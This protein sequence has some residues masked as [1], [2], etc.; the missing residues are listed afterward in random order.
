MR[1]NQL[2]KKVGKPYTRVEKYLV[3]ECGLEGIDGPNTKVD[4][5]VI[6]KV[7]YKFGLAEDNKEEAPKKVV[8]KTIEAVAAEIKPEEKGIKEA[9]HAINAPTPAEAVKPKINL[10][11]VQ[12][13]PTPIVS[14]EVASEEPVAEVVETENEEVVTPVLEVVEEPEVP[15]TNEEVTTVDTG[16]TTLHIDA[17]GV[18]KAPKVEL[19]GIK[20][21]GKIDLP[22]PKEEV[23]EEEE[24]G[25]E[26]VAEETV[27]SDE[28]PKEEVKKPAKPKKKKP[29]AD[30]IEARRLK[31]IEAQK[32]AEREKFELE[33]AER[34]QKEKEAK[35]QHY[36]DQMKDNQP[37]KKKVK[38]SKVDVDGAKEAKDTQKF[39]QKHKYEGVENL[40]T[41]QKIV[42]W[43]NT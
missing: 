18:I 2:A 8:L 37:A 20:V 29:S 11:D 5:E 25:T 34:L 33:N 12:V 22:Q 1:L 19:E 35:K 36:K 24:E 41:W 27:V 3:K 16:E 17:E 7:I 6:E 42:K 40:S 10:E 31:R 30:Q 23:I 15:A 28:A 13:N 38:K 26:V 4:E 14:E 43:F 39:E 9:D 32:Q 21:M